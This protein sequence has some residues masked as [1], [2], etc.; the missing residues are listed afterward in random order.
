LSGD[1]LDLAAYCGLYCGDCL[2]RQG[3]VAGP[4]YW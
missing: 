3:E 1:S 2:M 4:R